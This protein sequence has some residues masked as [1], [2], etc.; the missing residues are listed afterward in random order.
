MALCLCGPENRLSAV[1]PAQACLLRL[2]DTLPGLEVA[3]KSFS[4]HRQHPLPCP[5]CVSGAPRPGPPHLPLLSLSNSG[6]AA[7]AVFPALSQSIRPPSWARAAW[8][9]GGDGLDRLLNW[10]PPL[11][12]RPY[13]SATPASQGLRGER[14]RPFSLQ[15]ILAICLSAFP[16]LCR[17]SCLAPPE[18]AVHVSL[19]IS[20]APCEVDWGRGPTSSDRAHPHLHPLNQCAR[21][22]EIQ[23]CSFE[24]P[25]V[26]RI[27]GRRQEL[28]AAPPPS[29]CPLRPK[30]K[31]ETGGPRQACTKGQQRSPSLGKWPFPLALPAGWME[32]GTA[33][34]L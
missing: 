6:L 18:P 19:G 12:C 15:C 34:G 14:E 4:P 8:V 10:A 17:A 16:R 24:R 21:L 29:C 11:P 1:C 33:P 26:S 20:R 2:E 31:L 9:Q 7:Q 25:Q 13:R 32:K 30:G 27:W 23:Y 28:P 5:Q 22:M 3:S